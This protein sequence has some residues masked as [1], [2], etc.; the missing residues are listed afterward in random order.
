MQMM[1]CSDLELI[2]FF[3]L[4]VITM[5]EN[6]Q[7]FLCLLQNIAWK[8]QDSKRIIYKD[9]AKKKVEGGGGEITSWKIHQLSIWQPF[10][11]AS[12]DPYNVIVAAAATAAV[13]VA[14]AAALVAVL[15]VAAV[16]VVVVMVAPI[17]HLSVLTNHP[18]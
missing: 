16:V 9:K 14:A 2:H 5:T 15:A 7:L 4:F 12:F 10:R 13:L 1:F 8:N 18:L 11:P 3:F 17:T 6:L